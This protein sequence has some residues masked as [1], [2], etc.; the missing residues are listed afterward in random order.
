MKKCDTTGSCN[1]DLDALKK[2]NIIISKTED[3]NALYEFIDIFKAFSDPTRLKILCL[4]QNSDLCVC[5]MMH[6]LEKPQST[7]SHHL[8][9]LKNARLIKPHKKGVWIYY[10]LEKPEIGEFLDNFLLEKF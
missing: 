5:E 9:V 4:L 8:S 10:K 7:L 3:E 1:I 6:I 2:I